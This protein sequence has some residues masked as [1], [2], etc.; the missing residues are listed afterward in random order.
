MS[1]EFWLNL[2][3][4]FELSLFEAK[5]WQT[6]KGLPTLGKARKKKGGGIRP[7][8]RCEATTAMGRQIS[9]G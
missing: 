2:Q 1:P 9:L 8:P 5:S 4:I 3:K 7:E 6:I